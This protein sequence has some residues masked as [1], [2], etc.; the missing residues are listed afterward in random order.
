VQDTLGELNDIAVGGRLAQE[1]ATGQGRPET[2]TAFVAGR[3]AGMQK[4]RV[5]PLTRRA[6]DAI[7]ALADA[8]PFWK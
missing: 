4:A 1:T 7:D 2:D 6:E 5:G 3:I 8:K